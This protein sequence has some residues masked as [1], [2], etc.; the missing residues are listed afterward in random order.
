MTAPELTPAERVE[1]GH[2]LADVHSWAGL[3][4]RRLGTSEPSTTSILVDVGDMAKR[5]ND[6]RAL[7]GRAELP[8]DGGQ[9][10]GT[11]WV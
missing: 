2:A 11:G 8:S 1:V 4:W 6:I 3:T 7:L 9:P 5:L 10:A